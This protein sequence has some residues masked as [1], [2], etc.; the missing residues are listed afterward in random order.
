VGLAAVELG[1]ALGARVIAAASSEEKLE[2]AKAHGATDG[3]VYG[4]GPLDRDAQKAF[5]ASLKAKLGSSGADVVVDVVGG[6]LTEPALRATAWLGRFLV[7]GF[8]AGIAKIPANL[9]LLKSCD[10][11]GV[12]WGAAVERDKAAHHEA[13]DRLLQMLSDGRIKTRIHATYP[14]AASPAAIAELSS[15]AVLGKIVVTLD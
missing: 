6:D 8:P 11:R 9:P 4:K 12:F 2:V 13:M 15:R 1:R 10:V 3:V 14:L 5:S 7:I